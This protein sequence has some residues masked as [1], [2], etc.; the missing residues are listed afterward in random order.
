MKEEKTYALL[1]ADFIIKAVIAKK[2]DDNHLLD[3]LVADS[4]HR[5]VC[6]EMALREV[7]KHD[8][9]GSASWLKKTINSNK[10]ELYSDRDIVSGL[11]SFMGNA[12]MELYKDYLKICCDAMTACYYSQHY[13]SLEAFSIGNGIDS[14]MQI[15]RQN[16]LSVGAGESLGERKAMVLLQYLLFFHPNK[17]YVFCSDDRKARSGL[18][19]VTS[20][21][22]KSIMTV[23]WDMRRRG[24]AKD[25]AY[26][27]FYPYECFMTQ[28][29][30]V[31]GNIRVID[32]LSD[33]QISISCRQIFD[34]I[35]ED[36]YDSLQ[37][38]LLKYK[39]N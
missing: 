7:S 27:Y 24:V 39:R 28:N 17:V 15:L 18:Y 19:A 6:H 21:P 32:A 29:G 25:E 22:S 26:R 20:I 34:E 33:N 30:R 9:S 38:G 16:D 8:V 35:F 23:F 31:A 2:D 13:S 37:T 12:G 1:D 14:F 5:L 3:W 36:K 10:V 4:Q 11:C